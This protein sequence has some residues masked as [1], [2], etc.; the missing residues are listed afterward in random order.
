MRQNFRGAFVFLY[1]KQV[2]RTGNFSSMVLTCS[3]LPSRMGE[4]SGILV[5]K[6]KPSGPEL[7]GVIGRGG[8]VSEVLFFSTA[9]C[10][11]RFCGL[12]SYFVVASHCRTFKRA[13][14]RT[15]SYKL[16]IMNC[17]S[18]KGGVLATAGR[19]IVRKRGKLLY[20]FSILRLSGD[21][22]AVYGGSGSRLR[23]FTLDGVSEVGCRFG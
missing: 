2:V 20:T 13:L 12:S 23:G 21:V 22:T 10:P 14:L 6:S 3:G 5:I 17:G 15:V 16:P 8:L 1:L 11:C 19:L 4:G 7:M 9:S 18:S